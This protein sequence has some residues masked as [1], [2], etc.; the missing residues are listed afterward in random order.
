MNTT[1]EANSNQSSVMCSAVDI[2]RTVMYF[3]RL[4]LQLNSIVLR[5]KNYGKPQLRSELK[6]VLDLPQTITFFDKIL[7]KKFPKFELKRIT[8][9]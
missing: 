6:K 5:E 4:L 9:Y 2:G 3:S 7:N 1:L 8:F